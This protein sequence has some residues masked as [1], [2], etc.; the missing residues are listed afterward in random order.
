M[1]EMDTL[2]TIL[3]EQ[4]ILKTTFWSKENGRNNASI[5]RNLMVSSHRLGLMT[6]LKKKG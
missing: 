5:R 4:K 3:S 1:V 2:G 6:L